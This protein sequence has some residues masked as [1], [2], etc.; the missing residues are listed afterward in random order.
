MHATTGETVCSAFQAQETIAVS[1]RLLLPLDTPHP[2]TSAAGFNGGFCRPEGPT[3]VQGEPKDPRDFLL[4]VRQSKN[5]VVLRV[6]WLGLRNPKP[7]KSPFAVARPAGWTM[8]TW[9]DG[10]PTAPFAD[11]TRPY[12]G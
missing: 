3:R 6:T 7:S 10:H 9:T 4:R 5:E 12:R 2:Q 1:Q 8:S 11:D